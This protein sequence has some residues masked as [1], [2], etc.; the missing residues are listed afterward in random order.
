MN[1]HWDWSVILDNLPYIVG[2]IRLTLL[3]A[4]CAMGLSLVGGLVLALLRGS[5]Y[6]PVRACTTAFVEFFRTT[7][8][9]LQI[10]WIYYTLPI[11]VGFRPSA[12]STGVVALGLNVSAFNSVI[13]RAGIDSVVKTQMEAGLAL[14]MS[15]IQAMTRIVLPQAIR[16]V[17]PPLGSAWVSMF[18][19]TSLLSLIA[20]D[21]LTYRGLLLRAETY[22]DLEVLTFVALLYLALGYPQAKIVDSLFQRLRTKE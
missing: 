11:L 19:D 5:S 10:F 22:R 15:R 6:R 4:V 14:G 1:F 7:P 20:V 9:L 18:K 17:I 8:F 12:F 21:E 16:R 13:F 2:G 3:V